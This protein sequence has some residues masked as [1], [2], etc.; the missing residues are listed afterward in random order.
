MLIVPEIEELRKLEAPEWKAAF[1]ALQKIIETVN[2]L[3]II[4]GQGHPEGAITAPL[5]WI[6]C[7][8]DALMN[9]ALFVKLSETGNTGWAP[10]LNGQAGM[11]TTKRQIGGSTSSGVFT[12]VNPTTDAI[13]IP[14]NCHQMSFNLAFT[15]TGQARIKIGQNVSNVVAASGTVTVNGLPAGKKVSLVVEALASAG[16]VTAMLEIMETAIVVGGQLSGGTASTSGSTPAPSEPP[17][18]P[19][20]ERE[21]GWGEV[22]EL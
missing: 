12:Q 2:A 15:G 22:L 3:P 14:P 18:I 5:G 20:S 10:V 8:A 19:P 21:G 17:V 16:S 7:R 9:E 1:T 6:Y 4:R 13:I 11:V